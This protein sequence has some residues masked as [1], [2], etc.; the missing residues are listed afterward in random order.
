MEIKLKTLTPIWTGGVET[1]KM[2]RLNETGIIGSL[3]WWY[4]AI[5][6]GLGGSACDPSEHSCI[7]DPENPNNGLC[8]ACQVFGAT[9]WR[10][11]FRL[12]VQDVQMSEQPVTRSMKANR[13]YE[14]NRRQT[15]T[16]TWYFQNP[17]QAGQFSIQLQSLQPNFSL[18]PIQGLIQFVTDWAALGARPQMGFGVMEMTSERLGNNPFSSLRLTGNGSASNLPSLKNMFFARIKVE[19]GIDQETFNLK[20]DLRRLFAHDKNVRH[21]VMGTVQGDRMGSKI[22][23]SR[24]YADNLIRVW[25]WIPEQASAWNSTWNRQKALTALNAHLK[26]KYT[27]KTWREFDSPRDTSQ[28][29]TDVQAFLNSLWEGQE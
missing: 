20:Y 21:F 26:S 29:H 3:R 17:P 7:Y 25:G 8:N 15:R 16:S 12:V 22:F 18:E 2:D 11:R 19:N 28:Q 27:L 5:V 13:S 4:E 9:G 24:P 1:G 23:M 10:R 14:D 6:R